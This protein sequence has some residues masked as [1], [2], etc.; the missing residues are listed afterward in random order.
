MKRVTQKGDPMAILQIEDLTTQ[1]EAVVFPKTYERIC[2]ALQVDARLIIWAKIKS[3]DDQ[4]QII[5]DDAEPVEQV[6]MVMVELTPE[7]ATTLEERD[8]LRNILVSQSGEK[9][10]A[11][12]PVI[13]VVQAG[14]S[15]QLVRFGKQFW[16]HD[17][18]NAINAL[19]NANFPARIQ[20]L[21]N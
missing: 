13:G 5:V 6:Q 7:Q 18:I 20:P 17:S 1:S 8:R 16:V 10:K 14:T 12:I 2:N 19:Q 15:R 9:D 4:K 11:K 21:T 3:R